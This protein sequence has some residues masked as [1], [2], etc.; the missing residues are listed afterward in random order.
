[1]HS[2]VLRTPIRQRGGG[3]GAGGGRADCG[4]Q[5]ARRA[6]ARKCAERSSGASTQTH[7]RCHC[8]S[9]SCS[10]FRPAPWAA[11]APLPPAA[12]RTLVE[13]LAPRAVSVVRSLCAR[14]TCCPRPPAGRVRLFT[15]PPSVS[16]A[17][18]GAPRPL[19]HAAPA[20]PL[21]HIRLRRA[22]QPAAGP[23]SPLFHT[24]THLRAAPSVPAP[25]PW[26]RV[27]QRSDR[28]VGWQQRPGPGTVSGAQAHA[29]DAR[30]PLG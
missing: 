4:I 30:A 29:P 19:S 26:L 9:R 3:G 24:S 22:P 5:T 10:C 21:L 23:A 12:R 2:G 27:S 28:A 6:A 17:P 16:T 11:C 8:P 13:R 20:P 7:Q 15:T 14:L 1:M 25:A 18:P